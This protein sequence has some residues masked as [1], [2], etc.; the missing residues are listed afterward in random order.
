MKTELGAMALLTALNQLISRFPGQDPEVSRKLNQA[1]VSYWTG[2]VDE[3]G[4]VLDIDGLPI[5]AGRTPEVTPEAPELPD[6]EGITMPEIETQP[7]DPQ[8]GSEAQREDYWNQV[9]LTPVVPPRNPSQAPV[10]ATR[11][12]LRPAQV[13][14]TMPNMGYETVSP[15]RGQLAPNPFYGR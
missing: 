7:M 9:P 15:N 13:D 1:L 10:S 14:Q 8:E 4:R 6:S 11:E 5:E 2:N 3:A 12:Q